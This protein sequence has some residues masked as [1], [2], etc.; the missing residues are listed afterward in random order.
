MVLDRL[1]FISMCAAFRRG[2]HAHPIPFAF[3]RQAW[4]LFTYRA[5]MAPERAQRA[6][7]LGGELVRCYRTPVYLVFILYDHGWIVKVRFHPECEVQ[8]GLCCGLYLHHSEAMVAH[9]NVNLA[10]IGLGG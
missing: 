3:P 6:L 1:D 9:V 4:R 5:V 2:G 8:D 7:G 10:A